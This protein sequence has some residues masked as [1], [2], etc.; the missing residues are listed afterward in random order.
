[1]PEEIKPQY[2][3]TPSAEPSKKE[4][5]DIYTMPEKFMTLD[6]ETGGGG[7]NSKILFIVIAVIVVGI[8]IAAGI[9]VFQKYISPK[10]ENTNLIVVNNTNN[11]NQ[12]T[13]LNQ[14]I[15][16]NIN[17][18]ANKNTNANL[19]LNLF[20]M[21]N[22][23][24]QNG[25]LN[26]SVI[27]SSKDS[28]LD[29]LTDVEETLYGTEPQKADTDGDSYADGQEIINGYNP[30][31]TGRLEDMPEGQRLVTKYTSSSLN[32]TALYPA[33]WVK[34]N[35]SE[36]PDGVIFSTTT[37]EFINISPQDN[38]AGLSARDWYLAQ[39]PGIDTTKI[40]SATN[41]AK[42]LEGVKSLDSS[43]VYYVKDKKAYVINYNTNVLTEANFFDTFEMVY[44]SFQFVTSSTVNT[45]TNLN[46]NT[47]RNTN[48]NTN[49]NSNRNTNVNSNLNANQNTNTNRN[50]NTNTYTY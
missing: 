7:K 43:A 12:N 29:G 9:F 34:G 4:P 39:A 5:L 27:P 10:S 31:G 2:D 8:L 17:Q 49:A 23:A 3:N 30:L 47:N 33:S 11:A 42:N 28:D 18:N 19:N 38:P 25:N 45:N 14:N 46:A 37:G 24:N 44:R 13:N 1:M 26:I 6:K 32:F 22:A 21:N 15:N 50:S 20:N 41:W 36:N 40:K 35:D 48:V 16:Q